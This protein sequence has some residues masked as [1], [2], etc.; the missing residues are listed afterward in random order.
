[1]RIKATLTNINKT[2]RM[3]GTGKYSDT[4]QT[5]NWSQLTFFFWSLCCQSQEIPFEKTEKKVYENQKCLIE[6]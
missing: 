5:S 2:T 3:K 6:I 1:M 4:V